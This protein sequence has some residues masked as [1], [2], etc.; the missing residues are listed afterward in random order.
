M[1]MVFVLSLRSM[2]FVR[3]A[4]F[5]AIHPLVRSLTYSSHHHSNANKWMEDTDE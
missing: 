5:G 4:V 1:S 3:F 2:Y